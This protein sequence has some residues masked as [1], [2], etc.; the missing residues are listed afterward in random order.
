MVG[1]Q[2]KQLKSQIGGVLLNKIIHYTDKYFSF[3]DSPITECYFKDGKLGFE[4][5]YVSCFLDNQNVPAVYISEGNPQLIIKLDSLIKWTNW[6]TQIDYTNDFE[7]HLKDIVGIEFLSFEQLNDLGK[8]ILIGEE[9]EFIF[10]SF[11][12]I[13]EPTNL[14]FYRNLEDDEIEKYQLNDI[15][16]T[17][18]PV[19][20]FKQ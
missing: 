2:Q 12:I 8:I 6:E 19:N 17:D 15:P 1:F 7:I 14:Y 9:L 20:Y 5:E 13:V 11:E 10:E 16:K 4:F 3:H 18:L